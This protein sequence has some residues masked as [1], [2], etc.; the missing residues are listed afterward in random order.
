MTLQEM[1]S[2]ISIIDLVAG[3]VL[4]LFSVF[5]T[6]WGVRVMRRHTVPSSMRY[7]W[8]QVLA[9]A[10][11][12]SGADHIDDDVIRSA[13]QQ[14]LRAQGLSMMGAGAGMFLGVAGGFAV[15]QAMLHAPF[16]LPPEGLEILPF[17]PWY[18]GAFSGLAL[19]RRIGSQRHAQGRSDGVLTDGEPSRRISDY[20]SPLLV[21]IVA[22]PFL[23][24]SVVALIL[25]PGYVAFT[26]D[27]VRA[28]GLVPPPQWILA[29]YPGMLLL[30]VIVAEVCVWIMATS[31]ASIRL[32]DAALAQRFNMGI[33][34]QRM[35]HLYFMTL[36]FSTQLVQP[37]LYL[38]TSEGHVVDSSEWRM[39]LWLVLFFISVGV[40]LSLMS[41]MGRMGGRLT[42]WPWSKRAVRDGGAARGDG[43]V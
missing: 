19:S 31:P 35:S 5:F 10:L 39:V 7:G 20:R 14:W 24:F 34:R 40:G 18:L 1:G 6:R 8:E 38:F 22:L 12:D 25:A 28:S 41:T 37:A 43:A 29:V 30:M 36:L 23:V 2:G 4:A 9:F 15:L 33:L 27:I 21:L 26:P 17:I 16:A 13:E 3:I 11:R 32:R 42:G